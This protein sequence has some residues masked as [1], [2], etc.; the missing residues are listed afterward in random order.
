[1]VVIG[2]TA[3]YDSPVFE[4]PFELPKQ[5]S[6][7]GYFAVACLL[8]VPSGGILTGALSHWVGEQWG[9]WFDKSGAYSQMFCVIPLYALSIGLG[10]S[11]LRQEGRGSQICGAFVLLIDLVIGLNL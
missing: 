7:E 10:I 9:W 5:G 1:V 11:S 3:A 2:Q 6:D 4:T 8:L